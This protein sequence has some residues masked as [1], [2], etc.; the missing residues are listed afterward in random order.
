MRQRS[1]PPRKHLA[2][3]ASAAQLTIDCT[4]LYIGGTGNVTATLGSVT[5]EYV[6][7]QA[8]SILPGNFTHVTAATAT[9]IIA[10]GQ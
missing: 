8:G 6:N 4:G 10:L 3:T 1:D 2:I 5:L 7:V 9:G